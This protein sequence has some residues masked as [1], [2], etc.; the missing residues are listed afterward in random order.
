MCW[1]LY[2]WGDDLMIESFKFEWTDDEIREYF[3]TNW[4][5]TILEMC[6]M[7]GY[8]K[9]RIKDILLEKENENG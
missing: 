7:T 1:L 8:T 9:E 4:G 6:V 3:D 2:C 5:T